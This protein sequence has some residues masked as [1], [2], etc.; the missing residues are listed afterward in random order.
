VKFEWSH[1]KAESNAAKHGIAFEEATTVFGDPLSRTI[2]DPLH[3]DA[4]DRFVT[5]GVSSRGRTI[6]VVHTD[7][8]DNVRIISAR[9]ATRT[10]RMKY[11]EGL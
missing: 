6:V 11:E 8:G 5:M 1:A 3:S 2:P 10:E 7:R 9:E 4:E